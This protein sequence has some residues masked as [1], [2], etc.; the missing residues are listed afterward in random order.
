MVVPPRDPRDANPP[1]VISLRGLRAWY[2][3][4]QDV[5]DI[6]DF[7]VPPHTVVGLLG[8]NGA[9]KTTL[10]NCMSG[11]HEQFSVEDVQQGGRDSG[12]RD[13]GFRASR[14][15]VFTEHSGFAY[16]SFDAYLAF[17]SSTYRRPVDAREVAE[18][19]AG[20][21]FEPFRDKTIG[22]LSTGNRKKLY[23][24]AGLALRLPLLVLDEP[25]DGL[26]FTGTEFLYD[27]I[28]AYREYGSVLMSS[29][30]AESFERCC[31]Q[32]YMMRSGALEGPISEPDA[33]RQVRRLVRGD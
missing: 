32:L 29:H 20:F 19:S 13:P 6:T 27:A 11:V 12:F 24:I 9:G 22:A 16:W 33:L 18:L 17:L 31:D 4:G 30:I 15:T 25:V 26:D 3:P 7:A 5:L 23:L 1:P 2:V 21:A 10:I 14:Y 28:N 8:A